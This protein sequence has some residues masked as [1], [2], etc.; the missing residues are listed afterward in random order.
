MR[1]GA[2]VYYLHG[3]HLGSTSLT[4]DATGAIV[5]QSS[6]LPYGQERWTSGAAQTDFTFTGQRND[7]STHLIEMGARWYDPYL[8]RW[9]SADTM[10]PQAGNPQSLNRY[11]YVL[12]RPL[13]GGDPSGHDG[14]Y[15]FDPFTGEITD[16]LYELRAMW[17]YAGDVIHQKVEAVN[18][19][20]NSIA[21]S[22]PGQADASVW[23]IGASG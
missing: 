2:E 14:P 19:T 21:S 5:A 17:N 4:T 1:K 22:L 13:Q 23:S 6:Y 10:V 20:A 16:P 15:P 7:L 18:N 11:S 3:D 12:N 8:N 9:I